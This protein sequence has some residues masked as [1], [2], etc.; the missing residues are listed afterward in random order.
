MQIDVEAIFFAE[1]Y[2]HFLIHSKSK[3]FSI[4]TSLMSPQVA[5]VI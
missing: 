2:P 1:K 4:Y 3:I 5:L